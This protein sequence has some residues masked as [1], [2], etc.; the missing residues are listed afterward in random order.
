[1]KLNG[2][3]VAGLFILLAGLAT[4]GMVGSVHGA[5]QVEGQ[6]NINTA[7]VEEFVLLPMIGPSKAAAIVAFREENGPFES[8]G[9]MVN[10]KGIGRRTLQRLE[11]FL[12]L[13]GESDLRVVVVY[14][15]APV[16]AEE[17]K[18]EETEQ[19]KKS[20]Q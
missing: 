8:I 16:V 9:D 7:T 13:E 11:P 14:G 2:I 5:T 18:A 6:L 19:G 15:N 20:K 10:V 12:K 1:M 4:A 3:Y 17:G